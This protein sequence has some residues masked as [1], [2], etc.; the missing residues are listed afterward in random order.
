MEESELPVLL[1]PP[2]PSLRFTPAQLVSNIIA[3]MIERVFMTCLHQ[4][5]PY[6][7]TPLCPDPFIFTQYRVSALLSPARIGV[8]HSTLMQI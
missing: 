7:M 6:E 3:I 1:A 4:T 2:I 5:F 8:V